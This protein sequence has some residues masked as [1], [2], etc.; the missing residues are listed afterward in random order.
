MQVNAAPVAVAGDD[1]RVSV[2]QEIVLEG[3]RSYDVGGEIVEHLWDLGDGTTLTG[4]SGRHA[5]GA[6]GTYD[7]TLTVRDNSGVANGTGTGGF[8]VMVNAPPVAAAGPDRHV[9]IGEVITFDAGASADPD[10]ALVE[11]L[12]DF[13]DGAHGDGQ[14]VQYAYRR[15]GTYPVTLTVRDNSGTDSSIDSDQLTVVVNEPPVAEAG[16]DQLVSSSEVRFDGTGSRD[17]D[18]AIARYE[19]DFGDGVGGTGATP[20]HVYQKPGE[21]LVRLTVTDNSG[22]V[23]SSASDS[24]RVTVNAAPIADAGPDLV[25]APGQEL[26]FAAAGSL[27]PD[28]DVAEYLWQFKEGATRERPAGQLRLRPARDLS[29]PPRGARR[30]QPGPGGR[31]RRGQGR[32]QCAAGRARGA[33]HP[34]RAGRCGD[35]RCRRRVRSGWPDRLLPVGLQRPARADVRA[36][37]W[38]A[39]TPRPASIPRSSR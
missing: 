20:V 17:P 25:G 8:Q 4:P 5:Y 15:S 3:G 28:G 21:Y 18:G 26:A 39:P 19:W 33:R 9:A 14:M 38:S 35:L 1:R 36:R 11:Y 37:R 13:G 16:E 2:G 10:G 34:R 23:R 24:L 7:V 32:D 30:H 29:R 27:D 6:P 22:T 12:W 31:L